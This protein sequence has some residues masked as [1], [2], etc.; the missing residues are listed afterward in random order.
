MRSI[1]LLPRDDIALAPNIT[2]YQ[3]KVGSILYAAVITRPDVAFA[4]SRLAWFLTNPGPAHQAAA[5]QV[6]LYLQNAQGL[7]LQLGGEDDFIVY[8]DASFADN[9]MDRKSS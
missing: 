3:K 1:E 8:S 4:A 2:K 6:L 9:T 7:A 5:N